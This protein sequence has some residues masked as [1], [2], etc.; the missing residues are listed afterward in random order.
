MPRP[1][2]P[3]HVH[4]HYSIL[5]GATKIPQLIDIAV[6]NDMPAVAITDNGV[7]YG[8]LELYQKARAA[9]IKPIIGC[10][11]YVIDGDPTDRVTKRQ[12][13]RLVLLVKDYQGYQNLVKLVSKGQLEGFYY[14]PRV[15]WEQVAEYSA[16]LVCLTS[17]M[18]GPLGHPILRNN[19]EEA[20]ERARFLKS[21]FGEDLYLEI[22]DHGNEAEHRMNAEVVQIGKELGIE[23]VATHDSYY[24]KA[25][26]ATMHDIIL[27][28][29]NGKTLNDPSRNRFSG[30]T[31]Y[32]KNGDEVAQGFF[33][34]DRDIVD[35]AIDMTLTIADK[36]NLELE[37]E[38]SILPDYP[39]PEGMTPATYLEELVFKCAEERYPA[40]TDEI[41]ERLH[42]ELDVINHMGFPA[43]F[44]IVWDFM[45]YS[46]KNDIPVGPGRGSAAGSA[47][48]FVLGITDIDPIEHNL[49]FE[50]FLNPER[51]SMPDIDID[52]CIAKREQVIQYVTDL[53][54]KER[55]SQIITFGTLA[56]RAALKAVARVMEIP[57]AESDKWA[58]LIPATPG[59]K[60]KDAIAPETELGKLYESDP[61][62]KEVIDLALQIEGVNSNTGVHAAGVVIS[63]DPLDEVAPLQHSKEGQ[64]VTQFSM[65]DVAKMGLLK[66]DFLG[67]R[68]LTIME[69]TV[70][71]VL[72]HKNETLDL[73]HLA[74]DDAQVFKMLSAG[75]TDGVFQ[76]ESGGMKALVKELKP[77][78][79]EDINALVALFR[80]GPLNS[81]MVEEFV[82]RKHGKSKVEF[83]HPCLEP[84][85]KDTYGT[86]VY[87]EQIM[88]IAQVMGGYSL[89]QADLLR[90]AMGK[91]KEEEMNKQRATFLEGAI[92][93][94]IPEKVANDLFDDM[95]EFAKYC[96]NRSHSAA[97]AFVAYQTAWLKTH[98]PVEYLSA[99]LSSVSSDLD[100]IQLYILTARKMGI[101]VLPP[102]IN[103]SDADFTPDGQDIRF[104]LA[105]I[106]NVG[107]A[108]V[109]RIL[110]SRRD[111]GEFTS[112]EDFCER[113][114]MKTVNRRNLES[115][116]LVGAFDS[117][118]ISRKQLFNNID[119]LYQYAARLAERRETGQVSL[120]AALGGG[121][122]AE[123]T[124]YKEALVLTS[125][126]DEFTPKEIQKSEKELLG[127]YVTSHPLDDVIDVIPL[128]ATA[129]VKELGELSDGTHVILAGLI[130]SM[131]HK[132]TKT[133]KPM[134][135]G[136]LED[137]SGSVEFV[138]FSDSIEKF[139]ELLVDGGK[140]VISGKL[141]FRGDDSYSIVVNTMRPLEQLQVLEL[142]FKQA[143]RYEDVAY[144]REIF[145]QC[146][147]E[148]PVVLHWPDRTRMV[149]GQQFWVDSQA[150]VQA[151]RPLMDD[152]FRYVLEF[153]QDMPLPLA[154]TLP[155]ES[156]PDNSAPL[157]PEL[158]MVS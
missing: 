19:P 112:M 98:Y 7:M 72:K 52:F 37:L 106:K 117:F 109:D 45:N 138:A 2:V 123:D 97:Y 88:Q 137:L 131:V 32:V 42:L 154:P 46:R 142:K 104:G 53:Y 149:V 122:G 86:I 128:A 27:C 14:K 56:A 139:A 43:Y 82:K 70:R 8:M 81:G 152:H 119:T 99:L 31:F 62:V 39:V 129:S 10:E 59:T 63:K 80:P 118:G 92:N 9:G 147:G 114:D 29:Q 101:N 120:F 18:T 87:Q 95:T 3:L 96:F 16:G 57:F 36:C 113:V 34:L 61:K 102:D 35:R 17:G 85:L 155:E 51:I 110:E 67:L 49:L 148:D 130:T 58:K 78:N 103:K 121:G 21:V 33:N 1:Y 126:P 124:G 115:L 30:P 153:H 150:A 116:I 91:K 76:L 65:D 157:S 135:I 140:V 68:N 48:A 145:R 105:S 20:R 15:N 6:Q 133:N 28:L 107:E 127:S 125:E 83:P 134:R 41:R 100:K 69:N 94:N 12:N 108:V 89:G 38:K 71:L 158:S 25:E 40:V 23:L 93:N 132:I 151:L 136:Q 44:L 11:L 13:Y 66:M 50:R 54:G 111:K 24:P 75:Q 47:V 73:S 77:T 146:K 4:T 156:H 60:L 79:F 143:P 64:V 74:L 90:R 141:Q 55:V 26:H 84:I 22:Q 5:Q 144:L